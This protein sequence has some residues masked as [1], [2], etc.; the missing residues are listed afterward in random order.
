MAE[1]EADYRRALQ[2]D[3]TYADA[4]YNLGNLLLEKHRDDR[5]K[6][7]FERVIALGKDSVLTAKAQD[8]IRNLSTRSD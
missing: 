1:A 2:I 3:S 7:V 5:A 8:Q 4:W 6:E